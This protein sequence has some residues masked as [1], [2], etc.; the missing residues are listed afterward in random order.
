[1]NTADNVSTVEVTCDRCR[2]AGRIAS[3]A[4]VDGGIC[5]QCDGEGVIE[6][7]ERTCA[8]VAAPKA[9]ALAD[10]LYSVGIKATET[11]PYA[12]TIPQTFRTYEA[13]ER[14]CA[15]FRRSNG[16]HYVV[17]KSTAGEWRSRSGEVYGLA[18]VA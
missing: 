3:L 14:E 2:G 16:D 13:A 4:H 8:V 10:G 7:I 9:V 12:S 11:N 15:A 17:V 1:M 18:V 5:Y 6:Q